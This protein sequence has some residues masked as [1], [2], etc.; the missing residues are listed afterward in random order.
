MEIQTVG[1]HACVASTL[2]TKAPPTPAQFSFLKQDLPVAIEASCS[3]E[4]N[5]NI[6]A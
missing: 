1:G 2:L 4:F 6:D 5:S 3:D